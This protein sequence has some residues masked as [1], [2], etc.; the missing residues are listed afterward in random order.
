LKRARKEVIPNI[1]P[2]FDDQLN[3]KAQNIDK[4]LYPKYS[5]NK[6]NYNN[7]CIVNFKECSCSCRDLKK[8]HLLA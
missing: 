3:K 8:R 5:S 2:K 1:Y 6:V 4:S 7:I